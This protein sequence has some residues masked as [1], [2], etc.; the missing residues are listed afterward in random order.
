V[1]FLFYQQ[2]EIVFTNIIQKVKVIIRMLLLHSFFSNGDV[3]VSYKFSDLDVVGY[4]APWDYATPE[5]IEKFNQ[6]IKDN[7]I[8]CKKSYACE[9]ADKITDYYTYYDKDSE[10]ECYNKLVSDLSKDLFELINK[11][12]PTN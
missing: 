4:N 5:E 8:K 12:F 2:Q 3:T 7:E 11:Y 6:A 9:I 1:T 10:N